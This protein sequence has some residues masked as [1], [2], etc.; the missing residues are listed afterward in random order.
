M[1]KDDIIEKHQTVERKGSDL[2]AGKGY[3]MVYLTPYAAAKAMDEYAKQQAI[4]FASFRDSFKREESRQVREEQKRV[5]GMF[6]WI[7]RSDEEIYNQ[8]IE[9]SIK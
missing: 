6:S 5:G 7:G 4:A 1:T 2:I 8:F 3:D 9:Q